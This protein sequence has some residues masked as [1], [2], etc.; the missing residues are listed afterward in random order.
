MPRRRCSLTP[1]PLVHYH[2]LV[3]MAVFTIGVFVIAQTIAVLCVI[4]LLCTVL[5]L[6]GKSAC[7]LLWQ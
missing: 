5:H 2:F 6:C 7:P 3:W 1:P 4:D